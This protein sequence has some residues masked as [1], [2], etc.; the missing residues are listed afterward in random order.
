MSN[1]V[2]DDNRYSFPENVKEEGDMLLDSPVVDNV[3]DI[4]KDCRKKWGNNCSS[5]MANT[6]Y[7]CHTKKNES[8]IDNRILAYTL[9][10]SLKIEGFQNVDMQGNFGSVSKE[11][12]NIDIDSCLRGGTRKC[13]D[14]DFRLQTPLDP[15]GR[16]LC[17]QNSDFGDECET[18]NCNLKPEYWEQSPCDFDASCV[19]QRMG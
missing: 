1:T 12:W 2:S 8:A 13:P 15:E 4:G 6:H 5:C 17:A 9:F 11:G 19:R 14:N 10:D 16:L 18:A 3:C 7:D